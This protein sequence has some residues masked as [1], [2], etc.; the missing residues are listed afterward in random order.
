MEAK[1]RSKAFNCVDNVGMGVVVDSGI[2]HH[3]WRS[4]H[5]LAAKLRAEATI[6]SLRDKLRAAEWELSRWQTWWASWHTVEPWY[7]RFHEDSCIGSGTEELAATEP[8]TWQHQQQQQQLSEH[9]EIVNPE[10][11]EL[12]R[13][14]NNVNDYDNA[15]SNKAGSSDSA[16]DNSVF[17]AMSECM[18]SEENRRIGCG[19]ANPDLAGELADDQNY[20]RQ[21]D[22]SLRL[23]VETR[24][25]E[26]QAKL[27]A[28]SRA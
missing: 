27:Q 12:Q 22:L 5:R 1:L 9:H 2:T 7:E 16:G 26:V 8:T 21:L 17:G 15:G 4:Q 25:Q 23:M 13:E 6:Q 20:V 24:E 19:S 10:E 28:S 14:G 11:E 18:G 3:Q